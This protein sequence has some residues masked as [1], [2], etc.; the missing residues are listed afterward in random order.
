MSKRWYILGV[1]FALALATR[2]PG[3]AQVVPQTPPSALREWPSEPEPYLRL[4]SSLLLPGSG[5]AWN[6]DWVK[7]TAFFGIGVTTLAARVW[8]DGYLKANPSEPLRA[9][10]MALTIGIPTFW[11]WQAIDAYQQALPPELQPSPSPSPSTGPSP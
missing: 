4:G 7:G 1:A 6:G 5:H 2:Q 9:V 10:E 3:L 8:L 11:L